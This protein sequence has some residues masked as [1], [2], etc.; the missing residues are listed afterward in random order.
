MSKHP[1]FFRG[2]QEVLRVIDQVRGLDLAL[3][4]HSKH[5]LHFSSENVK[6]LCKKEAVYGA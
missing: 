5:H 2:S 1:A 3:Y 4:T 6:T